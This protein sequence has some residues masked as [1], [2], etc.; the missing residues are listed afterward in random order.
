[1][2]GVISLKKKTRQ[3]FAVVALAAFLLFSVFGTLGLVMTSHHECTGMHC[4]ICEGIAMIHRTVEIIQLS[5]IGIL[6]AVVFYKGILL[7]HSE[8][9]LPKFTFSTT[10]SLK[11]KLNN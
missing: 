3:F 8:K 10:V 9:T 7:L 11:I 2:K 5:A 6:L 1:M 4:H